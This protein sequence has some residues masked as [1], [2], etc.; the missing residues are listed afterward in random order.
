MDSEHVW[1]S[2]DTYEAI[3]R[4][5]GHYEGTLPVAEFNGKMFLRAGNLMWFSPDTEDS[6]NIAKI[7][8]RIILIKQGHGPTRMVR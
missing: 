3:V 1:M 8:S 7:N 4:N 6:D 2:E 5:C